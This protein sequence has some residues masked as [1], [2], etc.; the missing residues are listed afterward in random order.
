[1]ARFEK[2]QR[3]YSDYKRYRSRLVQGNNQVSRESRFTTGFL[4]RL[5]DE[6]TALDIQQST[7][8][9]EDMYFDRVM[10]QADLEKHAQVK[11]EAEAIF[12]QLEDED[13]SL[14]EDKEL[15][16]QFEEVR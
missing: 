2:F 3:E 9:D 12:S 1:M 10:I 14:S 5:L 7:Q 11:A 8:D 15:R 13:V 6:Q 4:Q 16:S